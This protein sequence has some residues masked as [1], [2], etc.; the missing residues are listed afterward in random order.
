[1]SNEMSKELKGEILTVLKEAVSGGS[2]HRIK[3]SK[4]E[5]SRRGDAVRYLEDIRAFVQERDETEMRVT[6]YGRDYYEKLTAPRW[7]WFRQNWFAATV[8]VATILFSAVVAGTSIANIVIGPTVTVIVR[9]PP[10][11]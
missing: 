6:A 10:V 9:M 3:V 5:M 2:G 7:Y 1:M 4:G 8:A 11:P